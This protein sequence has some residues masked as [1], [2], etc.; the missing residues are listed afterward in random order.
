MTGVS[1]A[2]YL[3]EPRKLLHR[4][5]AIGACA[6]RLGILP[7]LMLCLARVLPCSVELKRVLV[8]ESA[9]PAGVIPIIIARYYGGQPLTAV[10]IVLSTTAIG[11]VT[12]P[13]WIRAG[14]AWVGVG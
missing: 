14:L 1:M 4:D 2:D 11:L 9:M 3:D 13:F 7:V 5:I 8:V 10:Q 6:A 12:C